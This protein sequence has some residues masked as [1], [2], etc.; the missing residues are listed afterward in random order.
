[1]YGGGNDQIAF[2][3]D[4]DGAPQIFLVNADG[5]GT[6]DQITNIPD[7][8]C[9]PSWSPDGMRLAFISPCLARQ[10][11]YPGANLYAVNA[12][13]SG[14]SELTSNNAGDFDPA[15]SP[16]GTRIAFTSVRDGSRQ[17]YVLNLADNNI[18]AL[19]SFSTDVHLPDWSSQPAWSPSGTQI[20]YTAH[21]RLTDALQIRMMS[22]AGRGQTLLIP[23]GN[24]FWNF[25]SDW[26]SDGK[27]ILFS[28]TK[29]N[30]A[31][32][33]LMRFNYE[34][35][36]VDSVHMRAGTYGTHGDFSPDGSM[37]VY[38]STD[39]VDTT[40]IDYDIYL[41]KADGTGAIIRLTN[42]KT[43]EFDPAWRPLVTP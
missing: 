30:Q 18:K 27:T 8:A 12:D 13:G 16:D 33:W 26:S 7:G 6:Q 21:S 24:L 31:L 29:G 22:D 3:S 11:Q 17:I 42:A 37:V 43:M 39:L 41:I 15:W 23:R 5:S 38:E 19:T 9:Q 35:Q 1:L 36:T 34:N 40:R 14:I 32:G 10:D 2:A 28:E 20:I 25:L 4:R